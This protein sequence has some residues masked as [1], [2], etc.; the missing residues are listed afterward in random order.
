[1]K[2]DKLSKWLKFIIIGVGICGLTVYALVVPSLGKDLAYDYPEFSGFYTPWIVFIAVTAIPVAAA[3]CLC[4]KVAD[5]IGQDR[6]FSM[7]NAT[8]LKWISWLAAADSAY[9]FIG[10]IVMTLLNMNHPGIL[11][12]S[13]LV[14]FLGVAISIAAAALSHLVLKAADLQEQSDLTI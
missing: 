11:F 9:F 5:N 3:L 8:Y 7:S 12:M 14:I 13:L 1:M 10:N 6:S 4:W 2:Q